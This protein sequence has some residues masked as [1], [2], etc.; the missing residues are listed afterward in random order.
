MQETWRKNRS[1]K[2]SNLSPSTSPSPH[3][4]FIHQSFMCFTFAATIS[5]FG[6]P[7]ITEL[8]LIWHTN[9]LAHTHMRPLKVCSTKVLLKLAKPC[10]PGA[11][12]L[13]KLVISFYCA[14]LCCEQWALQY[15]LSECLKVFVSRARMEMWRSDSAER[16]RDGGR[17]DDGLEGTRGPW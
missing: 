7:S 17:G 5:S 11:F 9:T 4:P 2:C 1:E 15:F 13:K 6:K 14:S 16:E 8:N 10:F 12:C 3:L